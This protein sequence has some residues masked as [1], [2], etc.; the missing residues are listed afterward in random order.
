MT[1][2]RRRFARYADT[3]RNGAGENA[4]GSERDEDDPGETRPVAMV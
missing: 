2:G 1:G 3:E 4:Q